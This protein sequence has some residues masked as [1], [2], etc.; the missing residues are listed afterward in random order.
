LPL[1]GVLD[2][3]PPTDAQLGQLLA[4]AEWI[5][6]LARALVG[7]E[8]EDLAQE[9]W[10]SIL[11]QPPD[12]TRPPRPWLRRV[13]A[14]LRAAR[15][16]ARARRLRREA[17]CVEDVPRAADPETLAA[18]VQ[19]QIRLANLVVNLP[20]PFR[21]TVIARYYEGRSAS[22][23]AAVTGVP[24]G[25]VRW[26]VQRA[27]RL[28]RRQL[29]QEDGARSWRRSLLALG[30]PDG[31]TGRGLPHL[32][33]GGVAVKKGSVVAAF[34]LVVA[35]LS[36]LG[37]WQLWRARPTA[38][39]SRGAAGQRTAWRSGPGGAGPQLGAGP[40]TAALPSWFTQQGAASRR[41]AGR[42]VHGGQGVAG[43]TVSLT[44]VLTEAGY[45]PEAS[46]LTGADGRFDFG[47]QPP[48]RFAV[49][50]TA[51]GLTPAF[52]EI[53]VADPRARP[54]TDALI[55]ELQQCDHTLSGVVR[56]ASGGTIPGALVRRSLQGGAFGP[57]VAADAAGHYELCT[58][59]GTARLVV[60]A[61]GYGA[62]AVY[63]RVRGRATRDFVLVPEAHVFGRVVRSPDGAP[64]PHAHV[65]LHPAE[66]PGQREI[67]RWTLSDRDGRFHLDQVPAG[68][69][70]LS[71]HGDGAAETKW[72]DVQ[73]V[74]GELASGITI[75]LDPG[76]DVSGT[77]VAAGEPVVGAR[78]RLLGR[79]AS[80]PAR[81]VI[82]QEDGRFV[83][84]GV[85]QG[86]L[87]VD[88][89]GH[90]VVSPTVVSIATGPA[91]VAVEVAALGGIRGRVTRKGEPVEGAEVSASG[92][93]RS[94]H[95]T[96]SAADGRFQ[97]MGLDAATYEVSATSAS[98]GVF[99][100][101][102]AKVAHAEGALEEVEL[103]LDVGATISG[104]VLDASGGV[105]AG[106]HVR[107]LREDRDDDGEGM[108]DGE[109]RFIV[110]LLA[111]KG[112][113]RAEVRRSWSA[114]VTLTSASAFPA[115]IV[116]DGQSH[117]TDVVLRIDAASSAISGR[118]VMG[119]TVPAVDIKLVAVPVAMQTVELFAQCVDFPT[120]YSAVDG[121][122]VLD[123]LSAGQ[124]HV[125]ASSPSGATVTARA[126]PAG[127]RGLVI[128]LPAT[129]ALQGAL[130]GFTAQP[131]VFARLD[132]SMRRLLAEVRGDAYHLRGL[133]PGS[134]VVVAQN[135]G[136]AASAV[137]KIK[138]AV[139]TTVAFRAAPTAS[140]DGQVTEEGTGVP[141]AGVEC[142]VVPDLLAADE[143]Y[144]P[145]WMGMATR[146]VTDTAGRFVLE[147]VPSG[148]APLACL[149]NLATH[150]L[151]QVGLS[152]EPGRRQTVAVRITRKE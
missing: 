30:S 118:T 148:T 114:A 56:D 29:D 88:V 35:A 25:T 95:Q 89:E 90:R 42:V 124:Y 20:E 38:L 22:E 125:Q 34:I 58:R 2:H 120:A 73:V 72:V 61:A 129:G 141:L 126:V 145:G 21:A 71:A 8:G 50:A 105:L 96:T 60:A 52:Q 119:G 63:T 130:S 149:P 131:L 100:A 31:G 140:L 107:W 121:S 142:A 137:V 93:R 104:Q 69:H 143:A 77:V 151:T 14:N 134:Y 150:S 84:Q 10:V 9:A 86:E 128:E 5:R 85:A 102:P 135:D 54:A 55:L 91:T 101:T 41:V 109:G 80:A 13:V 40:G 127:R 45:V 133:S 15:V 17:A 47:L 32:L 66:R 28:L 62:L 43:A 144:Y 33:I 6:R 78:V 26:R 48:A 82:T 123:G 7:D 81:G 99:V 49:T 97:L 83:V 106:V 113:Y 67:S 27:L 122:F 19:L 11:R 36:S 92:G 4:E 76:V 75:T 59:E 152:L 68:K 64:V 23:I 94:S 136:E 70:R 111:G 87:V 16:R 46:V 147:R 139:S 74:P 115:V 103:E 57:G 79:D 37:I 110:R 39:L 1:R 116:P 53:V 108:T 44:S 24:A 3:V 65:F 146:A 117:V 132:G 18:R 138:P 98:L 12:A 112:R 51:S